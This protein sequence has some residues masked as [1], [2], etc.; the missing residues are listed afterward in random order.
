MRRVGGR[1]RFRPGGE[2]PR[3]ATAL[4]TLE[5]VTRA[6]APATVLARRLVPIEP[7]GENRFALDCPDP[8]PGMRYGVRAL[9]DLDGDEQP[10]AGDWATVQSYPVMTFGHADE[11]ELELVELRS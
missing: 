1:L 11:V 2:P 8:S 5:E 4:V 9:V 7:G 10:G 3:Q 6:D